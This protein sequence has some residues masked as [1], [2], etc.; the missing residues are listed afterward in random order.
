MQEQLKKSLSGKA[1]NQFSKAV[2]K[3]ICNLVE[4]MEEARDTTTDMKT[5]KKLN[6]D[7]HKSLDRFNTEKEEKR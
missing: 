4:T 6:V 3:F 5:S 7:F 2:V 1:D